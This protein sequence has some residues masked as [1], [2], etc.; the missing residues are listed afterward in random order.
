MNY[1]GLGEVKQDWYT[2][3]AKDN[4]IDG[5]C[6]FINRSNY[7]TSCIFKS[8]LKNRRSMSHFW[9]T[10]NRLSCILASCK[11]AVVLVWYESKLVQQLPV[12]TSSPIPNLNEIRPSIFG[13]K[14][15]RLTDWRAES[16]S[17][18]VQF[19]NFVQR[20]C[21]NSFHRQKRQTTSVFLCTA[22]HGQ[23]QI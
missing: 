2:R 23:V 1:A 4:S 17:I 11:V 18:C 8:W 14:P 22:Q 7:L 10:R 12:W 9:E 19:I 15:W 3:T 21:N 20:A 16:I 13:V 5:S 6:Q